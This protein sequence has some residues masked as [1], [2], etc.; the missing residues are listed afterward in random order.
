MTDPSK[1]EKPL[2]PHPDPSVTSVNTHFA[3]CLFG[4]K[5]YSVTQILIEAS[6]SNT[7]AFIIDIL[8]LKDLLLI[9]ANQSMILCRFLV[10]NEQMAPIRQR[11]KIARSTICSGVLSEL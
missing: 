7:L 5:R 11:M 9:G 3:L 6:T 1:N 4:V 10:V 8:S 2:L